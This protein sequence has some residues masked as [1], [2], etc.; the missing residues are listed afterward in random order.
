MDETANLK[1][2][3]ILAAQSQKHVTHNEALR[4]LD[5]IVQLA[6]LDK[7]LATPPGSPVEGSR[8]II[9]GSPSGAWAGHASHLAAW[10]DGAWAFYVPVAGWLAWVDDESQSY[11][12]SGGAWIPAPGGGGAALVPKGAW[13]SA[14]TYSTGD[15]VEHEGS[16]F[17]SNIDDNLDNEPDG[18]TPGSTSEWTYFS[19]GSGG[20]GGSGDVNPV[21]LVGVNATA[22][23]T[24]RL[25]VS[26]PASLFSHEGEGHQ[27]KINKD[28]AGDTASV[29]FQ[30]AFSGRA[31]FGLAGDDDFHVKVSPDGS[32]WHEGLVI[33]R[34]SGA[35]RSKAG[36]V[37][38]ASAATCDIGAAA[39]QRARVTGTTTITSFGSAAN[40]LRFVT[41]AGALTL[42]HNA[43]SLVLPGAGNIATVAGD[44]GIFASD[45]SGNWRCLAYQRASGAALASVGG[46]INPNLIINGDGAINQRVAGSGIADDTYAWDRH[47]VLTQT[48][49][50]AVSTVTDAADGVPYLFRMTQSQ[51]SAQRMGAATIL[52]ARDSKLHRGSTVTLSGKVRSSAAATIR[53]A[54]LEWTGTADT[55]TSDVVNSWT[56][57]TFTA[58]NFFLGSNLTVAGAGSLALSS[59]TLTDF[60]LSA[61]I[62]SSCNNLILMIWTDATAAQ[63]ATL[64][65]RWKLEAGASATAWIMRNPQQEMDLCWR[66]FQDIIRGN[67]GNTLGNFLSQRVVTTICDAPIKFPVPMR[68]TPVMLT[69][70]PTWA[71]SSPGANNQIGFFDNVAGG[72]A[73]I[74]GA[75]TVSDGGAS[76]PTATLLRFTAGTSFSG[77]AGSI[78]NV[79]IGGAGWVAVS[80]E[81]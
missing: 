24:N 59:N 28:T 58:G 18:A 52:E 31:E 78:G 13:S 61:A 73:T 37:D 75:L 79:Y 54:I 74:S 80:A 64:D 49:T 51:A 38:I 66:Y 47:Y 56:N 3:Y 32:T 36:Q 77:T 29:V 40:E 20:G 25:S 5:A 72:F 69:S 8:Y 76:S 67:G 81:L 68:T 45:G 63:T 70:G 1:L 42:T 53:W 39:A 60:T 65:W 33:D 4:A 11:L 6:V 30:T 41:F 16:A 27:L 48:S 50:I 55:V 57:G 15:L 35:V 14:T 34:S 2:P 26:S 22:D 46:G 44:T 21:S 62:S 7:D 17:L 10:Q 71:S 9:A 19:A 12:F 23:T 43:T